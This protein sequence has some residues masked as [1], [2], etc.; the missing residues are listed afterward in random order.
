V[1]LSDREQQLTLIQTVAATLFDICLLFVWFAQHKALLQ[2]S[3]AWGGVGAKKRLASTRQWGFANF[4]R[5]SLTPSLAPPTTAEE[6]W[7]ER[8]AT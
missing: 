3:F 7:R 6:Y 1:T 5:K 8:G 4:V 2:F